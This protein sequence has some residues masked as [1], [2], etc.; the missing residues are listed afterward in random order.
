MYNI[1]KKYELMNKITN[2]VNY[3]TVIKTNTNFFRKREI[4]YDVL[5]F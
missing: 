5:I 2:Y 4:N 3:I 1:E